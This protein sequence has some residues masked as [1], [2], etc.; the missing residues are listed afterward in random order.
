MGWVPNPVSFSKPPVTYRTSNSYTTPCYRRSWSKSVRLRLPGYTQVPFT[1]PRRPVHPDTSF[2]SRTGLSFVPPAVVHS[3]FYSSTTPLP[4][5]TPEMSVSKWVFLLFDLF[6]RLFLSVTPASFG[7]SAPKRPW[8]PSVP[9]PVLSLQ[10]SRLRNFS[11]L[12]DFG[13][14]SDTLN[15]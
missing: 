10:S 4:A 6:L 5:P 15:P 7:P 11:G 2:P 1:G 9:N 8:V 13:L 14:Y 3:S 12:I